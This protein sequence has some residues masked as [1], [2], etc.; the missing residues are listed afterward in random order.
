[1]PQGE[2]KYDAI[3][4]YAR[5]ETNADAAAVLIVGGDHGEGFS[6]Q[7]DVIFLRC[8]PDLLRH[9]ADQIEQDV[10]RGLDG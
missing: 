8:L 3:C 1:M 5:Q 10:N 4:T 9:M 7:G 2:G 6:V